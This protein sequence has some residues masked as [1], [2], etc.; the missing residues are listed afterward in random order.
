MSEEECPKYKDGD[1]VWVKLGP[2]WWP[3]EV[4]E[5]GPEDFTSKKPPLA[6]V[7]FFNES[8]YEFVKSHNNIYFYNCDRKNE[9]IKKGMDS[10]RGNNSHMEKFPGDVS[11]AEMRTEGNP[12]ILSD[13]MFAPQKKSNV[14]AEVF[15]SPSPKKT[16]K[17]GPKQP[18]GRGS[19]NSGKK[20]K[21]N[22][23][24]RRFLGCDDYEAHIRVQYPGKD[25]GHLSSDEEV[26]RE[27]I[28]R[29]NAEPT[30]S[31]NC[32]S[33]TFETNRLE[34]MLFH[35]QCH[36]KGIASPVQV[37]KKALPKKKKRIIHKHITSDDDRTNS[38]A[39]FVDTDSEEEIKPK[40]KRR[41]RA[42]G[43]GKKPKQKKSVEEEKTATDIRTNLLAEW[44]DSEENEEGETTKLDT[45][46][47]SVEETKGDAKE[48]KSEDQSKDLS[49]SC[50]D[51]EE[52]EEEDNSIV[53]TA[54]GRK[55]PR[56]IPP[57]DKRK[58]TDPDNE[59][60]SLPVAEDDENRM[61]ILK[62]NENLNDNSNPVQ[63]DA[64]VGKEEEE[65]FKELMDSTSVPELPEVPDTIKPPPQNSVDNKS[66]KVVD[67]KSENATEVA[68]KLTNPKKRFVK[69]FEDFELLQNEQR[70]AQ[71]ER[72]EELKKEKASSEAV[73]VEPIE[74]LPPK[75]PLIESMEV[76]PAE[77][78]PVAEVP[79][80]E[81]SPVAESP[82]V[83]EKN[84]EV[85]EEAVEPAKTTEE[86]KEANVVEARPEPV[87][88][89]VPEVVETKS[90]ESVETKESNDTLK[91]ID[92]NLQIS[93]LKCQIMSKLSDE[94]P[95]SPKSK[96]KSSHRTPRSKILESYRN[97]KY[98]EQKSRKSTE[99]EKE[100]SP[101]ESRREQEGRGRTRKSK[102]LKLQK[103]EPENDVEKIEEEPTTKEEAIKSDVM[104][105]IEAIPE[106]NPDEEIGKINQIDDYLND[107]LFDIP[108]KPES[109]KVAEEEGEEKKVEGDQNNE[110]RIKCAG[111]DDD[112][113]AELDI[114]IKTNLTNF[115]KS[116]DEMSALSTLAMVS[117]LEPGME[118]VVEEEKKAEEEPPKPT[119]SE[120][121]LVPID[122]NL[123]VVS[124]KDLADGQ[125][126]ITANAS[127]TYKKP[128]TLTSFSMDFSECNSNSTSD[129]AVSESSE[130]KHEEPKKAPG[131]ED[132]YDLEEHIPSQIVDKSKPAKEATPPP[133]SK[134]LERLTTPE[135]KTKD[136]SAAKIAKVPMTKE[137]A[138]VTKTK[139]V[140]KSSAAANKIVKAAA[141]AHPSKA[142]ILSE[143]I[144]KPVKP[145]SDGSVSV[146]KITSK[147]NLHDPDEIDT[148]II[149]KGAK[150]VDDDDDMEL[151]ANDDQSNEIPAKRYKKSTTGMDPKKL[152]VSSTAT[153][154]KKRGKAKILQQTIITP[155][156][157]IIQPSVTQATVT[158]TDDNVFD[159]NS[160][161]IVLSDQILTPES[162]ENMPIYL[163]DTV[164]STPEPAAKVQTAVVKKTPVTVQGQMRV[165]NKSIA[166]PATK[167]VKTPKILGSVGS[168]LIKHNSLTGSKHGKYVIVTQSSP[169]APTSKYT[170]GKKQ[171][172]I[173]RATGEL[174]STAGTLTKVQNIAPEPSGN[175]IMI[176]TNQQG[177]QQRVLLTPAQ[178][179]M[180]GY[181]TQ[182]AKMTK[183]LVKGNIIQKGKDGQMTAIPG[184]SGLISKNV[185]PSRLNSSQTLISSSGHVLTPIHPQQAKSM[186]LEKPMAG[187]KI[188]MQSHKVPM[189][190][191]PQKTILIKNQHGQTV[192]KIQGT[193][194]ALLDKQVAEQI[195]AI[196]ASGVLQQKQEILNYKSAPKSFRRSYAKKIETSSPKPVVQKVPPPP[197]PETAV[198]PLAPISPK[199]PE[200]AASQPEAKTQPERPLHQLVIQD[201]MG[202]QTTITEGQILA[203]PSE[204]VDGQPQSYMLVTLDESG[205][206]TPLNN[207][208]LLSLDPNLGLG[209]DL[210]NTVLQI[211]QSALKEE[212]VAQPEAVV[213]AAKTEPMVVTE[214]QEVVA[215]APKEE[216]KAPEAEAP[217]DQ[218]VESGVMQGVGG[219]PGQQLIVTGDPIA[220]QK[221]LESLTE[222]N[223]DL[224]NILASA[225]GSS[226]L[227]HADGQQIL[228]NTDSD[229]QMLL[230]VNT[231]NLNMT[232]STEGGGN[233]I[234]ATQPSKNQ[235]ILAA[236]LADTDVFQQEQNG[237]QGKV[238]QLSPNSALYPMNVGNVLETSLTLN[239]PIMTPL[240]VPS[241]NSKKI[242]DENDILTQV[243][244][245]VDLP[246]TITDPNIS[247]T[248][249][250]Q[251]VASL[252][253][254][255]L[256]SNL[257]LSLPISESTM[258]VASSEMNSPSFVY[259]L[260]SL[261][262]SVDMTQK[263]F[264]SSMPLL[265]EDGEE[266]AAEPKDKT[267]PTKGADEKS[268]EDK[269]EA[270]ITPE[271]SFLDE[272]E[273]LCTLG[274][275]MC[276]SLSEPPP[277]MF[278][279]SAVLS[280][281][282]IKADETSPKEE[283]KSGADSEM[284]EVELKIDDKGGDESVSSESVNPDTASVTETSSPN[285]M[286]EDSCE[287][288]V[289]PEIVT[290]LKEDRFDG[291]RGSED[292][293]DNNESKKCKFD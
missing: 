109:P 11:L 263:P 176:L 54:V 125:V 129:S 35:V 184:S 140:I 103:E 188:H 227:I 215:P 187:R 106:K 26:A 88:E 136:N 229:N 189:K 241:T 273:G 36:I 161:P 14:I 218:L 27:E 92:S 117:Q 127:P 287:I 78:P 288:P 53:H 9:F 226:I 149:Q 289:Q 115:N 141:P 19:K 122:G 225:E 50:F 138:K 193:D 255:E 280:S 220:A 224:A 275:E 63:N 105:E 237:A 22:I 142:V 271:G 232:E 291:K 234:F 62:V 259:S 20:P 24:H 282:Q 56:V 201:A 216:E 65:V 269:N 17:D 28:A 52:E 68:T 151:G 157:E 131:P 46:G 196:K 260:P 30:K 145:Q 170:V 257:E 86:E 158:T 262:P 160:M 284:E 95:E 183:T 55:I 202:N 48:T 258:T 133:A 198:P 10:F 153:S 34:V 12:N 33:C 283:A 186:R 200:P 217:Q 43:S 41:R 38:S 272:S 211:D 290:T 292:E 243:P 152:Q 208:A 76:P 119:K 128:V 96:G 277:D 265:T 126:E 84:E 146:Q 238:A 147:R 268:D 132:A 233:P 69:S 156:G 124:E 97:D 23:T 162:I 285:T 3:G 67:K 64:E 57:N 101:E 286:N 94:E 252:M 190:P 249:S 281:H 166:S 45:S 135:T 174:M 163:S 165:L 155:A 223:T 276:S 199:K 87:E 66:V 59:D 219:E 108:K 194:D 137:S 74:Q 44:S 77:P 175:K 204:T 213:E 246:I 236:A 116:D 49:K 37:K 104:K 261:D 274:G 134:L 1:I 221:F 40:P 60:A 13:P 107:F 112:H 266:A 191:P 171:T 93:K 81:P 182:G 89:K 73:I 31:F 195:E 80:A 231:D 279:L 113:E 169:A 72:E 247:Q 51:F 91:K 7:K 42:P 256:Q 8:T 240:E 180:M 110:V 251:Q 181:Q 203:L 244:K 209:G 212:A 179:K 172:L 144:I 130:P 207:E 192:R 206:L 148:F 99:E 154:V 177:Q 150:S 123:T 235:D 29:L 167:L 75:L 82:P 168:K 114:A 39:G 242:S 239:S 118:K 4:T 264:N 71:E 214:A 120:P 139:F 100:E 16:P 61:E 102:Y 164:Q 197:K 5:N 85:V 70:R 2:C 185:T 293:M 270:K 159:I 230:S 6:I 228:I 32:S 79:T 21:I 143:K 58:S 253:A 173:K 278:D 111:S 267:D 90:E 121:E 18:R 83:E 250:Q 178:Q 25:T 205:N 248:V 245:N 222:G 254:N 210:G 47:D 15:G 98:N